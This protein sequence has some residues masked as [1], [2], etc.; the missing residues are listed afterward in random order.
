MGTVHQS[1]LEPRIQTL[2]KSKKEGPVMSEQADDDWI[3]KSY[4][5]IKQHEAEEGWLSP[6]D[7]RML[8]EQHLPQETLDAWQDGYKSGFAD[9]NK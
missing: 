5:D 2:S 7:F 8:I 4:A 3:S 1:G 6:S 9:A